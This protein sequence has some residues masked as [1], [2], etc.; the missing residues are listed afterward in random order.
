MSEVVLAAR[1]VVKAF[2]T[3]AQTLTVLQGVDLELH[4]G[5]SAALLGVS[6]SG[7]STLIQI[8]GTL[9]RPTSGRV[10]LDGVDVFA[11]SGR[12]SN[13]LRNR[14]IGFV[15]QFH[16]LLPEFSAVE[17]VMLPLLIARMARGEARRRSMA[18]LAEV[19]LAERA[20]HRPGQLSGGEQQRVAIARA[21]VNEPDLLLADEPTGNLDRGTAEEVFS[22]L[23]RLNRE[24]QLTSLIVTHNPELADRLD[25]R[26]RLEDGRIVVPSV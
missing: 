17:N 3:P 12:E 7:K 19:G 4:R 5:E 13:R 15:Y 9:E 10:L 2:R 20:D 24:R 11:L 8:L 1:G 23:Q 25:H 16:R 21:I 6:G 14:R 22:I 26:F 18:V